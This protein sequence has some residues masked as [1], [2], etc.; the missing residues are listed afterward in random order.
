MQE[1]DPQKASKVILD[2]VKGEI[3]TLGVPLGKVPLTTIKMKIDSLHSDLEDNWKIAASTVIENE[4]L[5]KRVLLQCDIFQKKQNDQYVEN[6][7]NTFVITFYNFYKNIKH[8]TKSN[9]ISNAIRERHYHNQ[10]N[11]RNG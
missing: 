1:G 11:S 3:N 9:S 2:I 4:I 5:N 10:Q 6:R 8:K 7:M